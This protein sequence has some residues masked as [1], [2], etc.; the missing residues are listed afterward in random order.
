[1]K[2]MKQITV[3]AIVDAHGEHLSQASLESGISELGNT[4]EEAINKLIRLHPV[5]CGFERLEH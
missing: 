1:M 3:D 5:A 4:I 2:K